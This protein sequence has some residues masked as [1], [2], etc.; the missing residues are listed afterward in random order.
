[1]KCA[2]ARSINR[3][4]SPSA[5]RISPA[6]NS[7]ALVAAPEAFSQQGWSET[8]LRGTLGPM[9]CKAFAILFMLGLGIVAAPA[10]AQNN[11]KAVNDF[12]LQAGEAEQ[13]NDFDG[14]IRA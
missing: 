3:A 5:I 13:K 8:V 2:K 14:A 7:M 4:A 12:L 1:M 11:A 6:Q 10:A 9:R